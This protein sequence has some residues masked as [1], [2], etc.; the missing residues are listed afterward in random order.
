MAVSTTEEEIVKAARAILLKGDPLQERVEYVQQQ[1]HGDTAAI[2]G[3]ILI[4]H[5]AYMDDNDR[6]HGDISGEPAIGKT[7]AIERTLST[8]PQNDVM[9]LSE[10]SP[11]SL[12]YYAKEHDLAQKI[13]YIDD[14]RQDHI[15]LLKTFR[16]DGDSKPKHL[17]VK[18]GECLDLDVNARPVIFASSVTPLRDLQGQATSRALMLTY[19]K[20]NP[21]IEQEIRRKIRSR[22]RLS[23]LNKTEDT[24][25]LRVLQQVV[26]I[27]RTEG[28]SHV[29]IPFDAEEP[30]DGTRR[31]TGQFQKL[32]AAS[33]YIHQF[34]RP[35]LKVD[36]ERYVLATYEDLK[37]AAEFWMAFNVSQQFKIPPKALEILKVLPTVEPNPDPGA[38]SSKPMTSTRVH[39]VTK[40]PQST[41]KAYLDNLYDAGHVNRAQIK[42]PGS[43]WAYWIDP[44]LAKKLLAKE[45]KNK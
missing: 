30:T 13:I 2:K 1:H 4:A 15:P 21:L 16:N 38:Y 29:M 19:E 35:V 5:T 45:S 8:F 9:I 42:A 27:L 10:A 3:I 24:Q 22:T 33:A 34:Q 12:Y 36:G 37:V 17:T 20:P 26:E 41:C 31:D 28:T 14:A 39:Q 43:P 7:S 23:Q 32:I 25:K 11:M 6:L 18:D 44:D 40:I